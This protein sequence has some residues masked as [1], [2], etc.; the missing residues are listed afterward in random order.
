MR[1]WSAS[2]STAFWSGRERRLAIVE[3]SPI[4]LVAF[5]HDWQLARLRRQW[6]RVQVRVLK[7]VDGIDAPLPVEPQEFS[8]EGNST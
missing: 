6:G 4:K 3:F 1:L 8:E 7:G 2:D 5:L